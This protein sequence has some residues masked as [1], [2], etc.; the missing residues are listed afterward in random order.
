MA[1]AER[2]LYE[3]L[4]V[5][6]DAGHDEIKRAFRR[7]ARELHPDV[8]EA[9]DAEVRFRAVA[10]AYEVLSDPERRRTY[11]RFGHAGLRSGG[12]TPMGADFGSLSDVFA[13]FFGES[14]F[15]GGG[16]A[17]PLPARGPDVAAAVEIDLADAANGITLETRIR[18][19]RTCEP[20]GG[21]GAAPG[22]SPTTCP[23]CG[24]AGR[25]QQVSRTIL[26]QMVRTGACPR[27]DGAGTIVETPC[28]RCEGDGRILEDVPLELE[29]PAG[30]HDGQ[31]IRVRGAGHAGTLGG[32]PGDV[33]VTV[34]VR[35]LDG[36]RRDGDHLVARASVT[37]VEAAIGTTVRVPTPSGP[38]EVELPTGTQPG[39]VHVV[40]GRGMPSLETGRRGDLLVEVEVRVPTRL[41]AEQRLELL[42][43]EE[44]LGA[45]AYRDDDDG[46]LGKLKS[47]FR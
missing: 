5:P 28:E 22:T 18:A 25:V 10:E 43:L 35:P 27:C 47:A 36:L 30:I 31:R 40:R 41:S 21:T 26:G 11:D 46:L 44:E 24:G 45:D 12:F 42:R 3:L 8:S 23:A 1:T 19:A 14:L 33:Y 15:G 37:M 2:D 4:G 38:L 32:P 13:A 17:G 20:C 7:L 16:G 39:A 6:R 29:I 9:P 34:R